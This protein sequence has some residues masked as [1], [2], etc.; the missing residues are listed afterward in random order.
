MS[1]QK[2]CGTCER[3]NSILHV[4]YVWID[5]D[6]VNVTQGVS[7]DDEACKDFKPKDNACLTHN[8]C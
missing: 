6:T 4:C 8:T 5:E 2:K 7:P 1:E 3:F